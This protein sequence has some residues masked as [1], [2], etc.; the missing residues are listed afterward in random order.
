MYVVQSYF[1]VQELR[2]CNLLQIIVYCY[3]FSNIGEELASVCLEDLSMTEKPSTNLSVNTSA[4][5]M[6]TSKQLCE[7]VVKCLTSIRGSY[8][9]AFSHMQ[10]QVLMSRY[11]L[12]T[13]L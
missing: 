9:A 5:T 6:A 3:F 4:V 12:I 1:N 10:E 8:M 13:V 11:V 7:D 2:E